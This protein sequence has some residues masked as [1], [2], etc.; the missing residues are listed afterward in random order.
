MF[1]RIVVALNDL[2]ESQ[3]ALRTAIDLAQNFNAALATVSILGDLPAYTSFAVVVDPAAPIALKEDRRQIQRALH[4]GAARLAQEHGVVATSAIVEGRDTQSIL[5]FLKEY[6][7]DLL[8]IG[9][10]QHDF[11]LSRLWSSVYDLAQEASCSV[12]GVH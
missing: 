5:H 12:L 9:L 10:H 7:A 6:E 11:Y 1:S 3:R 4:E 2:P 8:V